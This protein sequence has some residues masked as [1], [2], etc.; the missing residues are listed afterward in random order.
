MPIGPICNPGLDAIR[1]AINPD[2]DIDAFFFVS[3]DAGTYYYAR[4]LAEHNA[5]IA[6][7][8]AVNKSLKD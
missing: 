3:D 5:N 6:K 1:A 2:P 4:T 7:A 8:N